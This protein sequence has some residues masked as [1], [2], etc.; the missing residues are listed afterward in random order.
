[1]SW[2]GCRIGEESDG[3]VDM[4]GDVRKEIRN[5]YS[6]LTVTLELTC[7]TKEGSRIPRFE[8]GI[9]I[10]IGDRLPAPLRQ[11]RQRAS[12]ARFEATAVF[13]LAVSTS[14]CRVCLVRNSVPVRSSAGEG[15]R[16]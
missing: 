6:R 11:L 3:D 14:I 7:G 12:S 16:P 13:A 15:A 10:E 8:G 1:M 2:G 5:L 9:G 4:P